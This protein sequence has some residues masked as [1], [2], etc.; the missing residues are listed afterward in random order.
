MN[1][2][3]HS[4]PALENSIKVDELLAEDNKLVEIRPHLGNHL[5]PVHLRIWRITFMFFA[6]LCF[7]Q[8]TCACHRVNRN[9]LRSN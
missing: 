1:G 4:T 3:M 9:E 7:V 8:C 5:R 6:C 2:H